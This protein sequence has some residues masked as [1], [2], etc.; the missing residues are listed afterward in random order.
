[1]YQSIPL[2]VAVPWATMTSARR[3]FSCANRSCFK[4]MRLVRR[5]SYDVSPCVIDVDVVTL[6][7]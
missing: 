2:F 6:R 7:A 4:S 3:L 1:M 5:R